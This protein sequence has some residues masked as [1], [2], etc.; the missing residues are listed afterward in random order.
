MRLVVGRERLRDRGGSR[1]R[2]RGETLP[3]CVPR[4]S[5]STFPYTYTLCPTQLCADGVTPG[6]QTAFHIVAATA[7]FTVPAVHE[8]LTGD[9]ADLP[10]FIS[11]SLGGSDTCTLQL[12]SGTGTSDVPLGV[13]ACF[14]GYLFGE[15]AGPATTAVTVTM[16]IPAT[17]TFC[18]TV[19]AFLPLVQAQILSAIEAG[20]G[21]VCAGAVADVTAGRFLCAP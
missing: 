18:Q 20:A 11:S 19:A 9:D 16:S 3:A 12:R 10:F 17:S 13:A 8:V 4:T 21:E 14:P 1:R 6:C 15:T 7:D 2:A 5:G